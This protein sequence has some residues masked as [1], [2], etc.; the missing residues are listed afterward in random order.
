ML[1]PDRALN[2]A[3]QLLHKAFGSPQ[4]A[5][6]AFIESVCEGG[7]IS[8]SEVGLEDFYSGLINCKIVL[9]AAGAGCLLNAA[10]TTERIFMRLAHNLQMGFAR[11]ALERGFD[12]D[13]VP[14]ELFIEYVD[15]EHKLL[16]SRFGR[17][18]KLSKN[19]VDTE[20]YKARVNL[21]Q[22]PADNDRNVVLGTP[23]N[24]SFLPKCNYCDAVGR[25]SEV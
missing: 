24:E 22:T 18:F 15:Q 6:S 3:L 5:V 14:F 13:V 2:E 10:S 20:G 23:S 17:L 8:H 12:M 1:S 9:E 25:G 21:I 4:V 16:C 19:K 7:V 11:L